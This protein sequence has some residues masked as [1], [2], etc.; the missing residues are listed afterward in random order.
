MCALA[1]A[2]AARARLPL[3]VRRRRRDAATS[4]AGRHPPRHAHRT[5]QRPH[6]PGERRRAVGARRADAAAPLHPRGLHSRLLGRCAATL[7][8]ATWAQPL[9]L[10]RSR[11][12]CAC[13]APAARAAA[14]L[15]AAAFHCRL[16]R[17]STAG[18]RGRR[19]TWSCHGRHQAP[20]PST[21]T[22][23]AR[24]ALCWVVWPNL[25][26]AAA[27]PSGILRDQHKPELN[28]H[29]RMA[30]A[31]GARCEMSW[32]DRAVT[33]VVSAL[34]DSHSVQKAHK[35]KGMAWRRSNRAHGLA[36]PG[37]GPSRAREPK[38]RPWRQVC[39]LSLSNGSPTV[40]CDGNVKT[41]HHTRTRRGPPPTESATLPVRA[42]R[43][44]AEAMAVA[45]AAVSKAVAVEAPSK[46]ALAAAR[47]GRSCQR[48]CASSALAGSYASSS[49]RPARS[50]TL[51]ASRPPSFLWWEPRTRQR[52]MPLRDCSRAARSRLSLT[53]SRRSTA[54]GPDTAH[55]LR[56][57]EWRRGGRL[58]R[59]AHPHHAA[60][61]P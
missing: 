31:L 60:R 22:A 11:A 49:S 15:A 40:S 47:M 14:S 39:S 13:G 16:P 23:L 21:T 55:A 12:R 33:H 43:T 57:N 5:A 42:A 20:P 59:R 19:S 30:E 17:R 10:G 6:R 37:S 50:P 28:P 61:R 25:L 2:R 56:A 48:S 46:V 58:R 54:A 38:A 3:V 29:W 34:P 8:A 18:C 35:T 9:V 45:A 26:C 51:S 1:A 24:P 52:W 53:P 27:A 32:G 7:G 44:L 41:R 4:P 36:G